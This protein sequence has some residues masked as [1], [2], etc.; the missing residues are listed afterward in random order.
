MKKALIVGINNYP[1]VPLYGCT[2]DANAIADIIESNGDGSPNF[3][4]R[5]EIDVPSKSKLKEMIAELFSG[6]CESS[7]LYFSGHGLLN[8]IGGYIV[9]PD[10]QNFDE[11]I[12]M[13]EILTLANRSNIKDRIIILDCCHSGAM[14]S[15]SLE[16]GSSH[17][18]EGISILTA[19][20]D[21]EAS[22]EINGHGVFTNLLIDA[23]KGGAADLRGHISPGGL[24]AYIDQAL[25]PWEQR[26][27]FKTNVTRFTTLR[28]IDPQVPINTLR[29]ILNYFPSPAEEYNLDPSFEDTN[30]TSIEH[31]IVEP[32][33]DPNNVAIFKDLQKFQSIGLIVPVEAEHMYYAAMESKSC[34]LTPLGYHYWRLIKDKRI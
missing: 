23:L 16:G 11:G 31:N 34:K 30:S 12:S 18:K 9:T 15:L 29:K 22:L 2:N 10:H 28:T 26:P 14:G 33:A 21:N 20:R 19:S 8:E 5:L 6:D 17:L 27:V 4:V 32:Y 13:D 25:G 3:N 1:T 7:L 24:Y